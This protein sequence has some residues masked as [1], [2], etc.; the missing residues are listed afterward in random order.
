MNIK[1][2]LL[3]LI[4]LPTIYAQHASANSTILN[5]SQPPEAP[6]EV[7]VLIEIPAGS[8]TKYEID[9]ETG[10]LFVDR[11]Q[12]MPVVYPA[13]YGTLPSTLAGDQDPLDAL[14]YTREPIVPGA[15]IKVRPI[16]ILHMLDAGEEDDKLI[17]V[18]T[19]EIDP[20]FADINTITDLPAIERERLLAFFRIYKDLPAGRKEVKI[21]KLEGR[22][23]ALAVIRAAVAAY[24]S[25]ATPAESSQQRQQLTP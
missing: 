2:F 3:M 12:S 15:L 23:K 6:D 11:Y 25:Q 18:P 24:N 19:T 13:N 10:F 22:K 16:G 7:Y 1:V 14:V 20:T 21:D 9:A 5:F 17:A 8:T 4:L